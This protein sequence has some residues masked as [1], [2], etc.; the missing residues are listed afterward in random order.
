M[1][2]HIDWNKLIRYFAG[3]SSGAEKEEIEQSLR[4][5]P[6]ARQFVESLQKIWQVKPR[7]SSEIDAEKA[8]EE[9][10]SATLPLKRREQM[11]WSRFWRSSARQYALRISAVFVLLVAVSYIIIRMTSISPQ[12]P[13][14]EDMVMREIST[15]PGHRAKIKFSDGTTAL[16]NSSTTIRFMEKFSHGAREVYLQGEAYF[17]VVPMPVASKNAATTEYSPFI[18]HAGDAVVE[19]LGTSFNVK[20]WSNDENVEVVVAKGK[21]AVQSSLDDEKT[22]VVLVRGEMSKVVRG[23]KPLAPRRMDLD[24]SLAW[25][26]GR[27]IF[28]NTPL[29]EVAKSLERRYG[30]RCEIT[31]SRLGSL[32]LTASFKEESVVEI[33]KV[34]SLSLNIVCQKS[35]GAVKFLPKKKSVQKNS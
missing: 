23:M 34:V 28:Q 16:L 2:N 27:L 1:D 21:V 25:I 4:S 29:G 8:W 12:A 17:D 32:P 10:S 20:A 6:L 13:S 26:D 3:E 30:L 5:D 31:D 22:N 7:D 15:E 18:V 14:Q 19:V 9:F 11:D 33:L 35:G 24:K